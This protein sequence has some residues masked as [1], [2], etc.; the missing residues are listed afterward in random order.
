MLLSSSN[1]RWREQ[2]RWEAAGDGFFIGKFNVL[3]DCFCG[4]PVETLVHN[5]RGCPDVRGDWGGAWQLVW[6]NSHVFPRK[7]RTMCDE[8]NTLCDSFFDVFQNT[9][10]SHLSQ[11]VCMVAFW[12]DE[13][14]VAVLWFCCVYVCQAFYHFSLHQL[15]F[16]Q[17]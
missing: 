14:R 3:P 6:K 1:N 10:W 12:L 13:H 7:V 5:V 17:W 4:W 2:F 9:F 11:E 8:P 16:K 15:T